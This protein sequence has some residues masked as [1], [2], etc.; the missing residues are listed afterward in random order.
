M[1]QKI[2]HA[3]VWRLAFVLLILAGIFS[4]L[5]WRVVIL[6]VVDKDFLQSQGDARSLR[7]VNVPAY[8]GM[9]LDRHNNVLAVST[10]VFDAWLSP[11]KFKIQKKSIIKLAKI[12]KINSQSLIKKIKSNSSRQFLYLKRALSPMQRH[13]I[14]SLNISGVALQKEYKRFYPLANVLAGVIGFTNIDDSGIEGLELAFNSYLAGEDGVKRVIKDRLGHIIDDLGMIQIP[15]Q[16][17]NINL[18]LDKRIQYASYRALKETVNKFNAKSGSLVVMDPNNGE[19][20][21]MA[22]YPSFN[23]NKR[24]VNRSS[25]YRNRA[26]IDLFEPGSVMK[27][28]SVASAL[29][30]GLYT[31]DTLI[32]TNPSWMMVDGNTIRDDHAN[33]VLSVTQV[34]KRSSNV[35]VTKMVL[36]SP[37]LQLDS[38]LRRVGF[39]R[40][41]SSGFPGETAGAFED[42]T[43]ASP[44]VLATLGFGYGMSATTLQLAQAYGVFANGGYLMP[45]SFLLSD[46]QN[47]AANQQVLSDD[48]SNQVLTMLEAVVEEN[49]TGRHARVHGYRV[50]GKTG[51]SRIAGRSGYDKNRHVASFVGI[52]PVSKPKLVIAVVIR[53]PRKISYYGGTVAA[54]LFSKVMGESLNILGIS[55]DKDLSN[56]K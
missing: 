38:L 28:F 41:S 29:D 4:C 30:S 43:F 44:F 49:G 36:S 48:V 31:P 40:L 53:E 10:P 5:I 16:G 56:I 7:D 27:A 14:K 6:T 15:R 52:G 23:P 46:K 1:K 24:M 26:V 39:G 17:Q 51:T 54:P 25:N 11:K 50:A 32:D 19:I 20:L 33:G 35:G 12:L 9:L 13:K 21:A 18:S 34:I 8:R 45:A 42:K 22:N 2:K 55:P 47:H 3:P 37:A